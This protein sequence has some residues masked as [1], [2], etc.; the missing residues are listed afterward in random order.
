LCCIKVAL[1]SFF[2]RLGEDAY[3]AVIKPEL[4]DFASQAFETL[5]QDALLALY[6]EATFLDIG[7]S[8][9]SF[10]QENP[11]SHRTAKLFEFY[12]PKPATEIQTPL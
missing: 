10:L 9:L 11:M 2:E 6:S 1:P 5:C 12:L 3:E 7:I 4:P 8:I